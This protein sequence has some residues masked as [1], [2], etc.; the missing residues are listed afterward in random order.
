[1]SS[2]WVLTA[3]QFNI[4]QHGSKFY[5][6]KLGTL[7]LY[8]YFE[9]KD[10]RLI[11]MNKGGSKVPTRW[12]LNLLIYKELRPWNFSFKLFR[13][14]LNMNCTPY[15]EQKRL[16]GTY[17]LVPLNNWLNQGSRAVECIWEGLACIRPYPW[18]SLPEKTRYREIISSGERFRE[19]MFKTE[20]KTC[21]YCLMIES[22]YQVQSSVF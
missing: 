8:S 6:I 20:F 16:Q 18:G 14:I 22:F 19:S 13:T 5:R 2:V 10:L 1:M 7:H 17:H 15:L 12:S 4:A 9:D 3:W 11:Q 21:N